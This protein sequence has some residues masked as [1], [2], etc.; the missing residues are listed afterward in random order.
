[1]PTAAAF[2][3]KRRQC[4]SHRN[5]LPDMIRTVVKTPE[6]YRADDERAARRASERSLKSPLIQTVSDIGSIMLLHRSK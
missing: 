4:F 5:G 3:A 1:M 6:P 2:A